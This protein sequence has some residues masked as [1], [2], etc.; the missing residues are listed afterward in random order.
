[1]DVRRTR[2]LTF[3]FAGMCYGA[4]GLFITANMGG[5]DPLIGA[6]MLLQIFAAV[7][8]GGTLIGGGR[9]G[10]VGTIFGALTLTVVV[11]IF[12]V[13]G[14]RT[15]YTPIVEGLIL[16]IAVSRLLAR[17]RL[18]GGGDHPLLAGD[19]AGA[20]GVL[21]SLQAAGRGRADSPR[22]TGPT[23]RRRLHCCRRPVAR[24]AP[25]GAALRRAGLPL[26]HRHPGYHARHLRGRL[27]AARLPQRHADPNR[28]FG[29]SRPRPGHG[30]HHRRARSLGAVDHDLPGDRSSPPSA[31]ASTR[32]RRGL[33]R[34]RSGSG[35]PSAS[36]TA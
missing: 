25:G 36:S 24:P 29:D 1:M 26:L 8:L 12:L 6:K 13:L 16:L 4:A 32:R 17:P 27:L 20:P 11:N 21:P 34:R 31:T 7:V 2:F 23:G 19:A 10:A 9:G 15:Y 5:G 30:H 14:V 18:A 22:G 33:S 28:L 3:T 35:S